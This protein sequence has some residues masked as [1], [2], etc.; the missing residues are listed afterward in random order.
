MVLPLF[1]VNGKLSSRTFFN[2]FTKIHVINIFFLPPWYLVFFYLYGR[3]FRKWWKQSL[4]LQL[5]KKFFNTRIFVWCGLYFYVL[6]F[7]LHYMMLAFQASLLSSKS[8][9]NESLDKLYF[10]W[11]QKLLICSISKKNTITFASNN[12]HLM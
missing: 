8:S 2:N 11:C 6:N 4:C 10:L 3:N 7:S 9:E 5:Q 1:S 12:S